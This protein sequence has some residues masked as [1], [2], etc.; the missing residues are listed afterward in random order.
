[1]DACAYD[2]MDTFMT[3]CGC[4]CEGPVDACMMALQ[5]P[6]G[7]CLAVNC[8]SLRGLLR[9]KGI[10]IGRKQDLGEKPM[11]QRS[12]CAGGPH[13]LACQSF[14]KVW[15]P[16]AAHPCSVCCCPGGFCG[17]LAGGNGGPQPQCGSPGLFVTAAGPGRRHIPAVAGAVPDGG[18]AVFGRPRC[19]N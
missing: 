10:I 18:W 11:N 4:G 2:V 19:L 14:F 9:L 17:A 13:K 12:A 16:H 1:M 15:I 6:S 3:W 7:M 5:V 8:K